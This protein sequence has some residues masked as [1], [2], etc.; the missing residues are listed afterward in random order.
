V[1]AIKK[2]TIFV[3]S[4][5][6]CL[7]ST[8]CA[9]KS[10]QLKFIKSIPNED[11]EALL[12]YTWTLKYGTYQSTVYASK[13][14]EMTILSNQQGDAVTFE[15]FELKEIHRIG[16]FRHFWQI[17]SD[18]ESKTLYK[19][20][21]YVGTFQC[22]EWQDAGKLVKDKIQDQIKVFRQTCR[23]E[24]NASAQNI[25]YLDEQDHVKYMEFFLLGEEHSIE[26]RKS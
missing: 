4:I 7:L 1:V 21:Q 3:I 6:L 24:N 14:G 23:A 19:Q 2:Y 18:T 13:I 15:N 16:R 8:G 20:G 9:I 25:I 5:Y 17:F 26:L 10:D 11:V 22:G 12:P